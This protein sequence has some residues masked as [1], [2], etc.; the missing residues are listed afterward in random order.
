[1]NHPD[2]LKAGHPAYFGSPVRAAGDGDQPFVDS[3]ILANYPLKTNQYG[4]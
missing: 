3:D 4:G 1:M 2:Q